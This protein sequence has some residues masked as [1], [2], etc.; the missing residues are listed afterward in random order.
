MTNPT[1][2]T[3]ARAIA[4]VHDLLPGQ[5]KR[6]RYQQRFILLI[7][8]NGQFYAVDDQC[9]HEEVSLAQGFLIG[10]KIQCPL[11]GSQFCLKT[12]QVQHEPATTNLQTYRLHLENDMIYLLE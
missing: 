2:P 7:H 9:P 3:H 5:M 11:H 1:V 10:D 6:I 8:Q 12:G 4:T